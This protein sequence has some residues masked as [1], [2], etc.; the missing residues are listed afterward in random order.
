MDLFSILC[1]VTFAL[2]TL[3][4]LILY[5]LLQKKQSNYSKLMM[6]L[7]LSEALYIFAEFVVIFPTDEFDDF[8]ETSL[9]YLLFEQ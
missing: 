8:F 4:S 7:C 9:N 5:I 1:C 3:S 6:Y 2:S